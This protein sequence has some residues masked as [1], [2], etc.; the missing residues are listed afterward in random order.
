MRILFASTRGAGHIGPLVPFAY[1]CVAA[2]HDVLFAAAPSTAPH[3]KRTGLPFAPVGEPDEAIMA[4]IWG[5]V[6][7]A[8]TGAEAG[9]IV[10]EEVFAGE[11]ARSALPGL[12]EL[13]GRWLPD[14]VVRE[15]CEFA[16]LLAAESIGV[17]DVHAACFLTVI[18]EHWYDVAPSLA[19]LRAAFGFAPPA[20]DQS[21]EPY[22]TL[23]PRALEHP[24]FPQFPG[25]RRFRGPATL[26]RALPDW[27]NGSSDPLVY[28]SFG[29]SAAGN[30]FFPDVYRGAVDA[31]ADLP[32]RVLLTVG[33]EVDPAELGTVPANTHVEPWVPQ[34]AV[35]T[36][37]A[38]MVGHGGSGS[39]LAAMAAGMPLAVVPLFADQPDNAERIA[40][41]GAGL[42][43]DGVSGLGD[44]VT[45]LLEDP[46]Y[47]ANARAV[48]SEI[49]AL[50][51]IAAAVPL[52][53][54]IA[55]RGL[56]VA[57]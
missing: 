32:V 11:F 23:A 55:E 35:M 13:A 38:A 15:T 19:P 20:R 51:P 30:G 33:T 43:L 31:L 48:A 42:R 47:R 41:L 45:A 1:A 56:P 36:H 5:R 7:A 16:S 54:D 28:V 4:E 12:L 22:L 17:P 27:W 50:E 57:A 24:D 2:G 39:T 18:N 6:K 46:A 9:K 25:T 40:A 44:A 49:A 37:A 14:V 52:L 34:G 53:A 21:Q 26:S 3:L 10:F 8:S 29:S